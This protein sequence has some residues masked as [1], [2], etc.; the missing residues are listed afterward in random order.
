MKR[1]VAIVAVNGLI[2][3]I[4][5]VV[6]ELIFG[7]W[8][9]PR[10]L[11]RLQLLRSVERTYDVSNLYPADDPI[12]TYTRDAHGLRGSHDTPGD[13]DLLTIGGSTTDQRFIR[14]GETWQDILEERLATGG[15]DLTVGNAGVDGQSTYGHI[16]NFEWWFPHVPDLAPDY[17]LFYVGLN[18]FHKEAGSNYDDLLGE[19]QPAGLARA[20]REQSALWHL[21]RTVRSTW[22]AMVVEKIGHQNVDFT[23]LGW[24]DEPLHSDYVFL[25]LR[26]DAYAARLQRLVALTHALGAA[27]IFVSQP[28]RHYRFTEQGLEGVDRRRPYEGHEINGV[29]TWHMMRRF[30]AVLATVAAE[31]DARFIDLARHPD[32]DDRDFYDFTHMTPRGAEKVGDLLYEALVE[33]DR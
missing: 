19:N 17:V 33:L 20:I 32:W 15:H 31:H 24:T 9:R 1:L 30:D 27:P 3:A 26:L 23:T 10:A 13:I 16:K 22:R 11:D 29:D 5:V 8:I 14:D 7:G 21:A 28:S 6:L 12:I 2:L 4:G 25:Q 18:D